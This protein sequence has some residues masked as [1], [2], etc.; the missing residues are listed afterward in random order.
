VP[1][2]SSCAL[3]ARSPPPLPVVRATV[4]AVAL[5]RRGRGGRGARGR[6]RAWACV[7]A[8][9]SRRRVRGRAYPSRP[10][11]LRRR[12]ASWHGRGGRVDVGASACAWRCCTRAQ[13]ALGPE[14][15]T[16][17]KTRYKKT[18]RR[19]SV[20]SCRAGI[21][22]ALVPIVSQSCPYRTCTLQNLE[23]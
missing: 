15:R 17:S 1:V 21:P 22:S 8:R 5:R 14:N 20:L 10:G 18:H 2:A 6:A 13:L 7:R 11:A 16:I 3:G 23:C 4:S 9:T 19:V 12:R